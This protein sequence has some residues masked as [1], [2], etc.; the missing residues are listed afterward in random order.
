LSD[1]IGLSRGLDH[2]E[3]REHR[4]AAADDVRELVGEAERPLQ[5]QVFL[6]QL[7]VL[8]LLPH[9]HLEQV[10]VERLA[11]IIAGAEAH[12]FDRGLGRGEGGDH[13]AEDVLVDLLRGTQD[14]DAAE[15]GHLDVRDQDVDRLAPEQIDRGA[16]VLGQQHFVAL[17]P[18]HDLQHLAHR[19]LIVDDQ[20]PRRAPIGGGRGR[21][22]DGVHDATPARA[23]R[24]TATVVPA[25]G[26]E[27]TWISPL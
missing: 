5:Q 7:A 20:D 22:G 2:L 25:P 18:Q 10:D 17:A 27:L 26:C 3:D 16:A 21:L 12:R 9:L 1:T 13:D 14:V 6:P 15:I 4:L 24:R 23:G 8:D 19:A 11:Q